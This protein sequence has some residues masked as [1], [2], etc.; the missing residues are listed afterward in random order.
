M[1]KDL[2]NKYIW[3]VNTI[4]QAKKISQEEL[5]RRWIRSSLSNGNE[6]PPRT[7]RN[8]L[9]AIQRIFDIN[10]AC[11]RK[12]G[13]TYYIEDAEEI[14]QGNVRKW[15]LNTFA[16]NNLL[17]ESRPL[18]QRILFEEIPSGQQHL[19]SIIEAMRDGVELE[20][21]HQSYWRDQPGTY[22]VQPY[23]V[24]VFRQRWYVTGF[25]KE[26]NALRTFS[27]DRILQ[28]KTLETK[29]NYPEEFDPQAYFADSFGIIRDEEVDTEIVRLKVTGLQRKYLRAL[30]LHHSQREVETKKDYSIIECTLQP[31]Y[32]FQQELLSRGAE[33]EVLAPDYLRLEMKAM[34]EELAKL[35]GTTKVE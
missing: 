11:D 31:T 13:Y 27:L 17:S 15:L 10:I 21:L 20:L 9:D 3:L 16:V 30:P 35:Y 18:K 4:Y 28:L 1:A 2:F 19:M 24:K 5:N 8:H 32:D 22:T 34:A 25:C 6:I 14:T 26:R 12:N 33:V 23:F 7:F 29:F